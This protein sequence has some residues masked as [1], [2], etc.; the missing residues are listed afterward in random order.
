MSRRL[1]DEERFIGVH[2]AV[3]DARITVRDGVLR[4]GGTAEADGPVLSGPAIGRH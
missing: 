4:I 3:I 2:K 1:S